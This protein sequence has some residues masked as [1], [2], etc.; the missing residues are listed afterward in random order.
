[1][2]A[3]TAYRVARLV[4][5]DPARASTDNPLS[6]IEDGAFVVDPDGTFSFVGHG[7]DLPHGIDTVALEGIVL[8]G[9]VDAHTHAAWVGSRHVEYALRLA[10]ADYRQIAAAGGGIVASHRAIAE[11][12][13]DAITRVLSARL[14]RMASLGVT[15]VEVKS[16]YGLTAELELRQLAAIAAAGRD[17][18]L[19]TIVPTFLGLHALPPEAR[20]DREAY[21]A[22]VVDEVL[23][24]VAA[25]KLASFVD[26]Y[27]DANA[28]TVE[29]ARRLA[30]RARSLGILPRLHVGQ[31]ADV[32]GAELAAD[33]GALSADHLE[34]VGARGIAAL[35]AGKVS[36]GLLP[37]ASFTLAQAPP[38]VAELR[39]AGVPLVVASDANPGTAP[40]E[41]L[42]LA[43]AFAV[44][45]YGLRPHE[46]I[47]GATRHAATSLGLAHRGVIRVGMQA[48]FGA[49]AWPHET[50][51]LQP[52]GTSAATLVVR[53]GVAIFRA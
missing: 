48:D 49:F 3:P 50:C 51:I 14:R 29:E 34:N 52:W 26:A 53:D 42:P 12:T 33:V 22:R 44:R 20:A 41:S 45:T 10:G 47:L 18:T 16:G 13:E 1:M 30:S 46:A 35:A 31:F 19:P 40:T 4:T 2:S 36:A 7:P 15:C 27:V 11:A 32:G 17:A 21:V 24:T 23:P 8:P 5:C 25:Q 37:I 38:P 6:V 9:L 28:F 43:M 39:R